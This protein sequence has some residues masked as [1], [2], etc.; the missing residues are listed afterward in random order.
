MTT[1]GSADEWARTR[2]VVS[3]FE[4]LDSCDSTNTALLTQPKP[5]PFSMVFSRNQKMGFGRH[6]RKWM[7]V[8]DKSYA[9][10]LYFPGWPDGTAKAREDGASWIPLVAGVAAIEALREST[11]VRFKLK[12]PNDIIVGRH[13]L[14]GILT[15]VHPTGGYVIGLGINVHD[16]PA[17]SAIGAV[18]L[19]DVTAV[20]PDFN[21]LFVSL[22]VSSFR[23][24]IVR[25]NIEFSKE[26]KEVMSTLGR[27]V[28]VEEIGHPP[29]TGRAVDLGTRGELVV[30][31]ESGDL[32]YMQAAD[33]W[34]MGASDER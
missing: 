18:A 31:N 6:G 29:W 16:S 34:H 33:V 20:P 5:H 22:W 32:I 19:G 1:S 24:K 23:E 12:W 26:V 30:M 15:Q 8:P 17:F 4:V 13:K 11:S 9:M 7:S 10:S 14:A 21:D 27:V 25:E 28:T 3:G 2:K